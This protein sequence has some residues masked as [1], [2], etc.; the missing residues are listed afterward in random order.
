MDEHLARVEL[1]LELCRQ[2]LQNKVLNNINIEHR[3]YNFYNNKRKEIIRLD[4]LL[5][6]K[7]F[8]KSSF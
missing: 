6:H 5:N 2:A 8:E 4:Q 3:K 1:N 7:K